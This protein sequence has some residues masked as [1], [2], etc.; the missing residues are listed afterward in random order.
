M[1][2]T[3]P[4]PE[5][6]VPVDGRRARGA[7][8][9]LRVLEAL[10]ALAGEGEIRPTAHDVAARAGVALRTVYHHFED[11]AELRKSALDLQLERNIATLAPIEPQ[12][13]LDT[14][15]Q[16]LAGQLRKVFE[17]L[18]PI[19]RAMLLDEHSAPEAVEGLRAFR[20]R[21]RTHIAQSFKTEI[22]ALT[23]GG[24]TLLDALDTATTWESWEYKRTS[25]GRSIAASEKTLVLTL[26]DLLTRRAS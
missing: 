10:L 22:A 19:R 26:Q 16:M 20:H 17:S 3:T 25:L 6:T 11:V 1:H 13:D 14:K 23:P 4:Q 5:E 2:L 7:R 15:I 24:R 21:R 8:T 9:R 12:A 18:T